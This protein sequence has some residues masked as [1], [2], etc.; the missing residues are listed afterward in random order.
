MV[1]VKVFPSF[2]ETGKEQ[3]L[4]NPHLNRQF[5]SISICQSND[6]L[7]A[8]RASSACINPADSR[9]HTRACGVWLLWPATFRGIANCLSNQQASITAQPQ[10]SSVYGYPGNPD[11]RSQRSG[12][13]G[14]NLAQP[15]IRACQ[16]TKRR[17]YW[18]SATTPPCTRLVPFALFRCHLV[19]LGALSPKIFLYSHFVC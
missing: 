19:P 6:F 15:S 16:H 1:R 12:A 17:S 14:M 7:R 8:Y 5:T 2:S 13:G 3:S 18:R 11:H 4:A 10:A 9:A